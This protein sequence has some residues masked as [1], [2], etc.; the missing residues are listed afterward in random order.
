MG[1]CFLMFAALGCTPEV[2][3][4]TPT[5]TGEPGAEVPE[6]APTTPG[7][8]CNEQ[9]DTWIDLRGE[10]FSPL[11]VDALADGGAR[12]VLPT[13][14]LTRVSSIEGDEDGEVFTVTLTSQD[15]EETAVRWIDGGLM[16]FRVDPALGLPA[17]VY[18]VTVT[19]ANGESVTKPGAFG[20]TP[21][22]SVDGIFDDLLCV[23]QAARSVTVT[24]DHFMVRGDE[25][26]TVTLADQ[27]YEVEAADDCRDLAP[28]FGA[29]R[30]CRSVTL[31]IGEGDLEPGRI[32]VG[33][34]NPAPSACTNDPAT[35]GVELVVVPP[36]SVADVQPEPV[37]SEQ[38]DYPEMV[39][40]GEGFLAITPNNSDDEALPTIAV[41]EQT[42]A[43]TS[44]D[45]CETLPG[46]V[47]EA[48]RVCN[49]VR[50]AMSA[51]DHSPGNQ[52]VTVTN[53]DP[54]GCDSTEPVTLTVVPPPELS[55]V[56]P[57]PI[58]T[59][60]GDNPM[61]LTGEHF[62]S[63][64]GATPTVQIGDAVYTS[65][66]SDCA[67]VE[68][69][70][71]DIQTCS[72]LTIT[73]PQGELEE[74]GVYDV[75]VTNPDPAACQTTEAVTLTIVP[76]PTV[77]EVVPDFFCAE[78][79]E[80]SLTIN[81]AGFLDIEGE[82]PTVTLGDQN[83]PAQSLDGCE[84]VPGVEGAQSCASLTVTV[85]AGLV[86]D[87]YDVAVTNPAPAGCV[88]EEDVTVL[89][90]GVPTVASI[91]PSLFCTSAGDTGVTVTGEGLLTVDG[92]LPEVLIGDNVFAA[93]SAEGC[94]S[95]EG[96]ASNDVQRCTSVTTTIPQDALPVD[97]YGVGVRNPDPVGC[98]SPIEP[99]VQTIV[100]GGPQVLG[101]QPLALCRGQFDGALTLEGTGFFSID[102]ALPTVVLN[103]ATPVPVEALD[104]C[105]PVVGF[106]GIQSCLSMSVTVPE[107]LRDDDLTVAVT[108]PAPVDCE[109]STLVLNIEEPP[110]INDVQP[111]KICDTG[112]SLTLTG[113]HFAEG[114]SVTLDGVAA[115][116]VE[117]VSANEA[118]ATWTGP[119]EAGLRELV[120]T[121][122]NS[123]F[124][125]FETLIRVTNGPVVF[126]VDP[127]V[128][129]NGI[130]IQAT[131]FLGNLFGGS[132]S[133]VF[134]TNSQDEDIDLEF[135]FDPQTPNRLQAIIPAGLDADIYDVTLLD[136]IGCDGTTEDLLQITDEVR[137]SIETVSP[138]FAWTQDNTSILVQGAETPPED[139]IGFEPTPRVYI[140]PS[141]P[142]PGDLA[143]ELRAATLINTRELS[144]VVRSGLPPGTYDVIAV[145]PDGTVG[146]LPSGL[147]VTAEPPPIVL[148]VAPGSWETNNPALSVTV[149]GDNFRDA[150]VSVLCKDSGGN[151]L[152]EPNIQTTVTDPQTLDL[153]VDTSTLAHLSICVLR[154][155]NND[156]G[157]FEEFSPVTVTNP[158]GNFVSFRQGTELTAAR[159]APAVFSG[160]PSRL[161]RFL[162]AFGG[163]EGDS[164]SA[165]SSGELTQLNSFG[166][167]GPWRAM[168]AP[169][170]EPR[171]LTRAVRVEDF[172]YLPGGHN[173]QGAVASVMRAQ[174][175][176]PLAVPVI[177]NLDFEFLDDDEGL[178][179][180]VYYYRVS[181]VLDAQAAAN[182]GGE[183]LPSEPQ[184]VFVPD[185]P[186][187]VSAILEW[188][189]VPDAVSYRVYRS[190]QANLVFGEETLLAEL[191]ADQ[192]SFIDDGS[193]EASDEIPLP[194]GALGV[195][196]E[197]ATLTNARF[198][199]GVAVAPDPT[200]PTLRHLF[201]AGGSDDL[202]VL[203]SIE[204]I[205]ITV[206][207]PASQT[208][209]PSVVSP[210]SLDVGRAG[211]EIVVASTEN[212]SL[213]GPGEVLLYA[214]SGE[215]NNNV[216][217]VIVTSIQAGGTLAGFAT[218]EPLRP[219]RRGYAAAAANNSL[220]AICGQ[221]GDPSTS[222]ASTELLNNTGALNN[223]NSLGNTNVTARVDMGRA[224]FGGFFYLLGGEVEGQPASNTLDF[225]IL[226]GVP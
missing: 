128:V 32:P 72:T 35:D 42:Y 14:K 100:A 93:E 196:H 27:T 134:L 169:L 89:A 75:T 212:A 102:D 130:S 23:A 76:P 221:G 68:G 210:T 46:P 63:I 207:G 157:T 205:T 148:N 146:L 174:V 124:G 172:V 132:V 208:V 24:G 123:C 85:T 1:G 65:E 6:E 135:T 96:P 117:V 53:P 10:D 17:G 199:H 66:V 127:P 223:W 54:A 186:Q 175:L 44:V 20:V 64:D 158:A 101:Q 110:V 115:E 105:E 80:A 197:V 51:G 77:A 168:P 214:L 49:T 225:S 213:L 164:A 82:L 36:P 33:L 38:L 219:F 22:P 155:T 119:L 189:A 83:F 50:F 179:T 151:F 67:A 57:Q 177:N 202:G 188:T 165:L 26:P 163:D 2:T 178:P 216:T 79:R 7:F 56:A 183:T 52:P 139:E 59:A 137:V 107:D 58:C 136:E 182:P 129:Y 125:V 29:W 167:P 106:D 62:L 73:V 218:A 47:N 108:N 161:T 28:V 45:D 200:D 147:T 191:P 81:G 114:M 180:G 88:S 98:R 41:G 222:G 55:E 195:W 43:A 131:I 215:G 220:V 40:T 9:L 203:D 86:A 3:G 78:D 152:P 121:N 217:D 113:D 116:S 61:T 211:L 103:D 209:A 104:D 70:A 176:D 109:T 4:P 8:A 190:P 37:C 15:S 154:V 13:V 224:V 181:A 184:P 92:A 140:N 162:Y 159:R 156:D 118:V 133:Q 18:D 16:A 60:Q 99:P 187:G 112:G 84:P 185:L 138:P 90:L 173:G 201:V 91:E 170:P 144:G 71:N 150:E 194:I 171:T 21:R 153:S 19:N 204:V 5:I 69:P 111:L 142:Q 97:V 48:V 120:A 34:T 94:E 74:P 12:V 126:F 141:D 192:R 149:E 31:T 30:A 25:R 39:V 198:G 226:G 166:E 160:V 11:V 87:S 145:N 143:T 206:E 193:D 122:P 95:V